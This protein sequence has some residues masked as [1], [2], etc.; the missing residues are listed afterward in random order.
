MKIRRRV[1][2]L[3]EELLPPP[4]EPPRFFRINFVDSR[5]GECYGFDP[6]KGDPNRKA[7]E[8]M[9]IRVDPHREPGWI[10]GRRHPRRRGFR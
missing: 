5:R 1:E 10:T 7:R 9:I 6:E 3:E 2:S 4:A 8:P